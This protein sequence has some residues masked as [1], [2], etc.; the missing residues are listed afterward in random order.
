MVQGYVLLVSKRSHNCAEDHG[1]A[2]PGNEELANVT[3][4][5]AVVA[6]EGIYVGAL[7]PVSRYKRSPTTKAQRKLD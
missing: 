5:V 1:R 2:K 6:V 3:L 7:K 4:V